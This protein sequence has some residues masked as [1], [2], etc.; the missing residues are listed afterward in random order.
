MAGS[1]ENPPPSKQALEKFQV[2]IKIHFIRAHFSELCC[3]FVFDFFAINFILVSLFTLPGMF[4]MFSC[5]I[6][7]IAW[8]ECGREWDNSL[9]SLYRMDADAH[10]ITCDS[11][12]VQWHSDTLADHV[13][14]VLGSSI[15]ATRGVLTGL[16]VFLLP[17]FLFTADHVF[18]L[19]KSLIVSTLNRRKVSEHWNLPNKEFIFRASWMNVGYPLKEYVR[20]IKLMSE[21]KAS[22]ENSF[23]AGRCN[24]FVGKI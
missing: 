11:Y 22:C 2:K 5:R 8:G 4:G 3:C 13:S 17:L 15:F 9:G 10:R 21:W 19:T 1:R 14:Y 18:N 12:W 7:W 24:E 16:L 23:Y 6:T 20:A